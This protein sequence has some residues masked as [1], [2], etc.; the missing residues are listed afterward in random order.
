[1]SAEA[2]DPKATLVYWEKRRL[3]Y[4]AVLL[5]WGGFW[6]LGFIDYFGWVG[7]FFN[8][9]AFGLVAN[10]FYCLG[11][12]CEVYASVLLNRSL[13]RYRSLLFGLGMAFSSV[14]VALGAVAGMLNLGM[15]AD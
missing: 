2:H 13:G 9:L 4:N 10:V 14:V 12:L 1:M 5:V 6:S 7:Y 3:I 8:V 11:P 15:L